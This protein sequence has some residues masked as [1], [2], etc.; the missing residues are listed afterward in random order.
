VPILV[1]FSL[2]KKIQP[3]RGEAGVAPVGMPS[4]V[5]RSKTAEAMVWLNFLF[6]Y[7]Q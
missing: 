4:K 5:L 2:L 7:L 1:V 3:W 6:F